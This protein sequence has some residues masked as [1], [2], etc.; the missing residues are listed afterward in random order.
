[1]PSPE[2][3]RGR[4]IAIGHS[5][6]D[7]GKALALIGL[8]SSGIENNRLDHYSDLDFF[9]IAKK[10]FK[11]IFLQDLAWLSTIQAVVYQFRNTADGYKILFDDGVFCEFAVFEL[12]ELENIPFAEGSIIWKEDVVDEDIR[13]PLRQHD[14]V[15][16]TVDWQ[17]NEA[18]TNLYVGLCR[19]RRGEILSAQRF[20]QHYALDRLIALL[21]EVEKALSGADDPFAPE[22]RLEER[23][24]GFAKK[25]P[26]MAGGYHHCIEAASAIL[27]FLKA[28]FEINPAIEVEIMRL[29]NEV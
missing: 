19:Y 9:V 12:T 15:A 5:V 3:L 7:G 24:P 13:R 21:P 8:G 2:L 4:L 27:D 25:L 10:G 22:R 20:I 26:T 16:H 29:I 28:H 11:Q 1:M 17:L 6:R 14:A 18:L 23:F